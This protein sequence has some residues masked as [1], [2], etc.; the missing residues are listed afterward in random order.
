[1]GVAKKFG[2]KKLEKKWGREKRE[3]NAT[4]PTSASE[5]V[6]TDEMRALR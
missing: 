1:V 3:R 2:S 4:T 5:R 6:M